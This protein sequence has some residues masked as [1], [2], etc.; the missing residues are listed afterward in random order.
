[1]APRMTEAEACFTV[2]GR[3]EFPLD[4]LRYDSCW[5]FS[6]LDAVKMRREGEKREV[7]L[8][9]VVYKSGVVATVGRWHSFGW[10]VL[11]D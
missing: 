4:M 5:P 9:T 1:M 3:G 11:N 6:S 7:V 2:R 10:K 8:R